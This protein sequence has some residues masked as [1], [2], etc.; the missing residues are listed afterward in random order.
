MTEPSDTAVNL[1]TI[2]RIFHEL[3]FKN[4]TRISEKALQLSGQYIRLFINEAIIRSNELRLEEIKEQG[5]VDGI[6]NVKKDMGEDEEEVPDMT[7][8]EDFEEPLT[9]MPAIEED[10]TLDARHLSKVA[11]VLLLD[12]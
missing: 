11:G 2:S 3:S 6:D 4:N 7:M 5:Q 12:F 10:D 9:Q 1:K 8:D